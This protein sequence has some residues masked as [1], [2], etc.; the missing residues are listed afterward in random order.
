VACDNLN[1]ASV[2]FIKWIKEEMIPLCQINCAFSIE[3]V[4]NEAREKKY[5]ENLYKIQ[6]YVNAVMIPMCHKEDY[7]LVNNRYSFLFNDF[8]VTYDEPIMVNR[9]LAYS[10]GDVDWY[11]KPIEYRYNS[12]HC[13]ADREEIVTPHGL[14]MCGEITRKPDWVSDEEWEKFGKDKEYQGAGYKEVM[15]W[16]GCTTCEKNSFCPGMCFVTYY[17]QKY[18]FNNRKCLY[19]S[20]EEFKKSGLKGGE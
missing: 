8:K 17:A 13:N 15:D 10:F 5:F 14:F 2:E 6:K 11:L 4:P 7:D 9:E 1:D 16:Y 19:R 12:P 3:K 20:Q 18:L